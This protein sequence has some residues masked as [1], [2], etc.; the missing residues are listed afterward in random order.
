MENL[1]INKNVIG[2]IGLVVIALA[3]LVL[4]GCSDGGGSKSS[5]N[6]CSAHAYY[7]Q[8]DGQWYNSPSDRKVCNP[9]P[10]VGA[11]GC[12][13]G[14][15]IVRSPYEY[16]TSYDPRYM[17]DT[18]SN[19]NYHTNANSYR[20]IC[21]NQ[22]GPGWDYVSNNGGYYYVNQG[23]LNTS[24]NAGFNINAGFNTGWN[25]GYSYS[26]PPTIYYPNNNGNS[27][28]NTLLSLGVLA[29]LIYTLN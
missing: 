8:Y 1:A 22:Y 26:T 5:K 23:L 10:G 27:T 9:L 11:N 14:E 4:T 12:N 25:S 21:M 19:L 6:A 15:A 3:T 24:L 28:A 13:S 20:E 7:D 17:Y 29:A 16:N 18:R 2:K